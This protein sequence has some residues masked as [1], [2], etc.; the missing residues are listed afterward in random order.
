[1]AGCS[2]VVTDP[3]AI[4]AASATPRPLMQRMLGAMAHAPVL[5]VGTLL[6]APREAGS[7]PSRSSDAGASATCLS[8]AQAY[9]LSLDTQSAT[10]PRYQPASTRDAIEVFG[11]AIGAFAAA[12]YS[13]QRAAESCVTPPPT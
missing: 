7:E 11:R 3:T 8:P 9:Q 1:M 10:M 4:D 12:R 6:P 13:A 2:A 5:L